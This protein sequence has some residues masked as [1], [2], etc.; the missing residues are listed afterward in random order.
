MQ[1]NQEMVNMEKNQTDNSIVGPCLDKLVATEIMGNN[2]VYDEIFGVLE[3]HTNTNGSNVYYPLRNYSENIQFARLVIAQMVRM[4]CTV[5]AAYLNTEDR[6]E[7]ICK[8]ALRAV[9]QR[10]RKEKAIKTRATLKVIK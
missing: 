4:A 6:P 9:S 5:E 2:V 1:W 3:M 8:A 10:K 7:V